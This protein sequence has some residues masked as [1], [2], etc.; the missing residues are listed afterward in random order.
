MT[1][2]KRIIGVIATLLLMLVVIPSQ[3]ALAAVPVRVAFIGDSITGA[4]N[5]AY[6]R[7]VD[8]D[9]TAA[10]VVH[11]FFVKGVSGAPC[12]DL[13]TVF[14][15]WLIDTQPNVVFIYCGVNDARLGL[16][17]AQTRTALKS[18]AG[19][20]VNFA[21]HPSVYIASIGYSNPVGVGMARVDAEADVNNAVYDVVTID[22]PNVTASVDLTMVPGETPWK[23]TDGVHL[24]TGGNTVG[25]NNGEN[26]TGRAITHSQYFWNAVGAVGTPPPLFCGMLGR[27]RGN[28]PP[29][30]AACTTLT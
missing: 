21:T 17:R 8:A 11:T 18:M 3:P 9:L 26:A 23:V 29:A 25:V 20:A 19:M 14:N 22:Y 12:Q 2:A 24:T 4:A 15:Q 30:N 27:W 7:Q 10:G 5:G 16:T 28:Q 13:N 1:H 6:T